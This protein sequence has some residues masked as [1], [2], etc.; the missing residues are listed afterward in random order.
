M[1]TPIGVTSSSGRRP[2]TRSQNAVMSTQ[3]IPGS[4][5]NTL[6]YPVRLGIRA[7]SATKLRLWETLK[8]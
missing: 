4:K 8:L 3:N 1:L 5:P 7:P 6:A 2:I